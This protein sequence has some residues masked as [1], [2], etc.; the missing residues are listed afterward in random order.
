MA[1]VG[2][3]SFGEVWT[4]K[5]NGKPRV[6]VQK[7]YEGLWAPCIAENIKAEVE[8]LTLRCPYFP[9]L[10][11]S[12]HNYW[13][14]WCIIMEYIEGGTLQEYAKNEKLKDNLPAQKTIAYQIADGLKFLHVRKLTHGL[15]FNLFFLIL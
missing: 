2:K 4:V 8:V 9:E 3:G 6:F 15:V 5:I 1:Y 14:S 10:F 11:Y 12:G 7:I 13:S